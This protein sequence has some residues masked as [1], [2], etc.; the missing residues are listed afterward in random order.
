MTPLGTVP[1]TQLP[2]TVRA[3]LTARAAGDVDGALLAFAPDA[4]VVDQGRTFQGT[5]GVRTFLSTAGAEFTFTTDEIGAER[6]DDTSWLV[7]VRI[8]GDFPGGIADLTYRFELSDRLVRSLHI[9][10]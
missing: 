7:Q 1:L 4:E 2:D 10:G 5:E 6:V 8:E 9:T 3:Y